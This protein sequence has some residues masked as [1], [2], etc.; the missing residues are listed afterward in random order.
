MI[1][2]DCKT[3][4]LSKALNMYSVFLGVFCLF[5]LGT[6]MI[7]TSMM[8][9]VSARSEKIDTDTVSQKMALSGGYHIM[10]YP[11]EIVTFT[12]VITNE[13]VLPDIFG[14]EATSEHHWPVLLSQ[15]EIT[16]TTQTSGTIWL[17]LPLGV[18]EAM[19]FNVQISVPAEMLS[20]TINI[21]AGIT[22]TI[23]VTATSSVS[24]TVY[25]VVT[26]TLTI[27]AYLLQSVFLPLIT[28]QRP[29]IVKLGADFA[30]PL[31]SAELLEYD[32]PLAQAMGI[33]WVR[34]YLPWEEIEPAPGEYHWE[35][36][37]V[38]VDRV[39][40]LGLY[41]LA[42]VYGPPAWAAV[43]NCGPI[44]DTAAFQV[45]LDNLL[46]RYGM[47]IDAWEFVNEPD[48][49]YPHPWGATAGCW[50]LYPDL[51]ADQLRVF[52]ER[53]KEA[54]ASDL[55]VFGGL[56]YD[57]WINGNVARDFFTQTLQHGA[58]QYFDVA[59]LHYYP[60]NFVEFPTMAHKI[61]EIREIMERNGVYEKR[62]WVTETGMWVNDV[63]VPGFEGSI[64]KQ[65]NFIAKEFARGFGSGVDNIFWFDVVERPLAD[66]VVHRWL[67][68]M[69]HQPVNG[70]TTYQTF[71]EQVAGLYAKGAYSKVP[72]GIEAYVFDKGERSVYVLWSNTVPQT[73][74]LPAVNAA[75]LT[76][77]DGDFTTELPVEAGEATF[78]VGIVPVFVEV[79]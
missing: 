22:D 64:E 78:D 48:G 50:G 61:E 31:P 53:I 29:P 51:Y 2:F 63:G 39:V 46:T 76:D 43:E 37:D 21:I 38:I 7:R 5:G 54:G 4:R 68:D 34:V 58:G 40:E 18:G 71:A 69:E 77:R 62:I 49:M 27:N 56:A 59:N 73:V 79:H 28:C 30:A 47:H 52:H 35:V 17:P 16:G 45:F 44:S 36:Y 57:N 65:R 13:G 12:H 26:D 33:G 19:T 8:Q 1:M 20:G 25:G 42:L 41:P 14:I 55:V 6:I 11:G 32:I 24:P 60:I 75:V 72:A 10:T 15:L 67:I 74:S 9:S 3:G 66:D 70:Y 23:V